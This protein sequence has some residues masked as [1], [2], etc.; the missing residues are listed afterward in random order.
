MHQRALHGLFALTLAFGAATVHV[1]PAEA[2]RGGRVAAGV[3]AG[4]IA[5]GILGGYAHSRG[6]RYHRAECFR[7][8][9]R[10]RWVRGGC[11]HDRYGDYICRRGYRKCWRPL[12][13][14]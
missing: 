10:C 2:G 12:Y 3:A 13:C 11:W 5:L 9:R 14:D 6:R 7:G 8:P 4:I 1:Q